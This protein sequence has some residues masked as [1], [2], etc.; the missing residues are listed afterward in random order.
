M[1]TAALTFCQT[2]DFERFYP[3]TVLE[4]GGDIIFFWVARMAM[5]GTYLTGK[6]PFKEVFFH[7]MVLD[8]EFRKMSKSLGNV[9]DP[10]EV[11]L[12]KAADTDHSMLS[13][14]RRHHPGKDA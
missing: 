9:I 6:M 1:T 13:G 7:G 4:T 14:H 11:R 5:L 12:T 8:G 3:N 10:L 2:E